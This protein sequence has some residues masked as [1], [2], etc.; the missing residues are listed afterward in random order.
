M[1]H[2]QRD[3]QALLK[4]TR[5]LKG[6][7]EALERALVAGAECDDLLQQLAAVRG[8]A[9]GL[10]AEVLEGHVRGHLG[11]RSKAELAPVLQ[12]IRRYLR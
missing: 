4:R 2:V 10:M 9:N 12:M 1:A 3:R 5:R 7:V 8:A 6:Q 11:L